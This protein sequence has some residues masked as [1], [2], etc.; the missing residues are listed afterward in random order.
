M[1]EFEHLPA[2]SELTFY[3]VDYL[4]QS[5]CEEMYK[6]GIQNQSPKQRLIAILKK[7]R[8]GVNEYYV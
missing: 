4:N 7:F 1:I 2:W 3:S 6:C 8:F 5:K